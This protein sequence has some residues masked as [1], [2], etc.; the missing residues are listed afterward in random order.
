MTPERAA[1]SLK[2]LNKSVRIGGSVNPAVEAALVSVGSMA[3]VV[4]ITATTSTTAVLRPRHSPRVLLFHGVIGEKSVSFFLDCGSAYNLI[5]ADFVR[6]IGLKTEKSAKNFSFQLANGTTLPNRGWVN[7]LAFSIGPEYSDVDDFAVFPS[8]GPDIVLG[9]QWLSKHKTLIDWRA[10][11]LAT[12]T[13]RITAVTPGSTPPQPICQPRK[14]HSPGSS[15]PQPVAAESTLAEFVTA[16]S[17]ARICKKGAEPVFA[18]VPKFLADS[19]SFEPDSLT[20]VFSVRASGS[21]VSLS[22]MERAI[23]ETYK[24]IFADLPAGPNWNLGTEH[25]IK[26]EEGSHPVARRP[27]RLSLPEQDELQRQMKKLLDL[28]FIQPSSSPYGAPVLFVRKKD[29]TF[30]MCIDY[31]ALNKQT[32]RDSYPLPL[33]DDLLDSLQGAKYFSKLDLRSGYHQVPIAREDVPK[34]AFR[35]R[36]GSYEFLTMPFGLVNAPA[37]FQRLMN[38]VLAD[39]VG[40]SVVV[41]LDDILIYSPDLESH[42]RHIHDVL[43]TLRDHRLFAA[44]E[45]CE[46]FRTSVTFLGYVVSHNSLKVDPSKV[47][48]VRDW[49]PPS[50]IGQLR[51]LLGFFNYLRKFVRGFAAIAAPLTDL[52]CGDIDP[53]SGDR[54]PKKSTSPIVWTPTLQTALDR[55]KMAITTAPVLR[56][57]DLTKPFIVETD[58]SK[59]AVGAILWQQHGTD[60]LPVAFL[61]RRLPPAKAIQAPRDLELEAIEMAFV[62]WRSYLLGVKFVVWTDHASLQFMHSTKVLSGKLARAQLH[63]NEFDF[64]VHYR[65]GRVNRADALSRITSGPLAEPVESR[66]DVSTI[67]TAP[68]LSVPPAA[69]PVTAGSPPLLVPLPVPVA[70]QPAINC[71]PDLLSRIRSLY[72]ND[73]AVRGWLRAV[74]SRDGRQGKRFGLSSK[75]VLYRHS[76]HGARVVVPKNDLLRTD[77]LQWFHDAPIAAHP[78]AGIMLTAIAERFYWPNLDKD[79]KDF[80]ASC[81][82]CARSKHSTLPRAGLLQP[83]PVPT[84]P[85]EQ[86]SMDFVGPLSASSS[87]NTMLFVVVDTFSKR[88]VLTAAKNTEA[89]QVADMFFDRVIVDHGFP[90]VIIS[91]RDPRFISELWQQLTTRAGIRLNMSTSRH[92]ETDGQTERVNKFVIERVRAMVSHDQANWDRLLPDIQ[93]A[94]NNSDQ[95]SIGMTPF[96]ADTGR[97]AR[98]PLDGDIAPGLSGPDRL[99]RLK[100]IHD[101]VIANSLKAKQQQAISANQHRRDIEFEVGDRVY[102]KASHMHDDTEAARPSTKLRKLYIGAFI[103]TEKRSSVNY[104]LKLPDG[105][106]LHPVF[107]ISCLKKYTPSPERFASRKPAPADPPLLGE[108]DLYEVRQILQTRTKG[109]GKNRHLEHL[110][111]W[112]GYPDSEN[113]WVRVDNFEEASER[114]HIARFPIPSSDDALMMPPPASD[115]AAPLGPAS[116][117]APPVAFPESA[118]P[119]LPT[120]APTPSGS[121][122]PLLH[123]PT[124]FVSDSESRKPDSESNVPEA[125]STGAPN[126]TR[127]SSRA[128]VRTTFFEP[129]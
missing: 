122:L 38:T 107:H 94:V 36:A 90:K 74:Q 82:P 31:R 47:A 96:E 19:V 3:S 129:G 71:A 50:N 72:Q 75:G 43:S 15:L 66:D 45:K 62:A 12:D 60:R 59:D 4:A 14:A 39:F 32:I 10:G 29:G 116:L 87:G 73:A 61:S 22:A 76:S 124:P 88:V 109:R 115:D 117:V 8:C 41:Y 104:K 125:T 33:V 93:F 17:L 99:S 49:V 100:T 89:A 95:A 23:F 18:V 103:I 67:I 27:Y 64:T 80:V 106:K 79:V 69:P 57:P 121:S 1:A 78:G 111:S 81:E 91:D 51:S 101:M 34:T 11:I 102:I 84:H 83:L 16:K 44:P 108:P 20:E 123:S 126:A 25:S 26:L 58:A 40:T 110:V 30:R 127:T 53:R 28:G 35:S 55:L 86:V 68:V 6:Q 48:A 105:R 70:D 97:K 7:D 114:L 120:S 63:L 85:W 65:P 113:S 52:L 98:H 24:P 119:V 21:R 77:I 92:P 118:T 9:M 112:K 56:L 54:L 37:T 2:R 128:R 13:W 42:E 46:F 5:S